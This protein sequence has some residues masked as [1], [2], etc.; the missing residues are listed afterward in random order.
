MPEQNRAP[1][2]W[3]RGGEVALTLS[4][5]LLAR[6]I[7]RGSARVDALRAE[8]A[9]LNAG[10]EAAGQAPHHE[11]EESTQIRFATHWN[12]N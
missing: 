6:E 2:E 5:G 10:L 8:F 9:R 11:P 12:Q 4:V 1:T 7:A 3:R